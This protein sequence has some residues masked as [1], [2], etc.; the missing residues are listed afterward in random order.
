[1]FTDVFCLATLFDA[2][3]PSELILTLNS[4]FQVGGYFYSANSHI[5]GKKNV[6]TPARLFTNVSVIPPFL[7][8]LKKQ[9]YIFEML[10]QNSVKKK[11]HFCSY[12]YLL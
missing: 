12:L 10:M 8:S 7:H 1:M 3:I 5:R 6:V 11:L 4:D 9:F 2:G